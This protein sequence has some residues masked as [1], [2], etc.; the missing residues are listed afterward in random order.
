MYE[1]RLRRLLAVF[2]VLLGVIGARAFSLQV[3]GAEESAGRTW[4]SLADRSREF[5][6]H[7]RRGEILW[8]DGSKMVSNVPTYGLEILWGTVDLRI[9][10]TVEDLRAAYPAGLSAERRSA[11]ESKLRRVR[12]KLLMPAGATQPQQRWACRYCGTQRASRGAPTRRCRDCTSLDY[13]EVP[14]LY[15]EDLAILLETSVHRVHVALIAAMGR[16]EMNTHWRSHAMLARIPDSAVE[17]LSLF[18]ER[19]AGLVPLARNGREVDAAGRMIAGG[20]RLPDREDLA[21]LTDERRAARGLHV[22]RTESVS[23]ALV[24]SS[25][26][27]KE[28]DELLRGIPGLSERSRTRASDF[29]ARTDV[30]RPVQDGTDLR[31]TL[32]RNVQLLA[33]EEVERGAPEGGHGAAVVLDV[34]SGAVIALASTSRDA[35]DHARSHVMPGSVYKIVTAV[36][37]LEAGHSPDEILTCEGRARIATGGRYVCMHSDGDIAL[38][39]AFVRSCN[40][41][42]SQ[43]AAAVGADG[44][45]AAARR[46]GLA[47]RPLLGTFGSGRSTRAGLEYSRPGKGDP[48]LWR[49]WNLPQIGI[50]QGAASASPLQIAVAYARIAAGGRLLQPFVLER[51]RPDPA[52][53]P[54]DP[55]LARWA[56]FLRDAARSVVADEEHGTARREAALAALR[57]AGKT[58]TADTQVRGVKRNNTSFVGYAPYD[59]PRYCAIVVFENMPQKRYG[60]EAAGDPVAR[61]L[62]EALRE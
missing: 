23:P 21:R 2:Y 8:A 48:E 34:R 36:A 11:L 49:R 56:P 39:D 62:A 25:L 37:L 29:E 18:P 9:V 19:F 20:T 44:L 43:Q 4:A 26:I 13:E 10:P 22:F 5:I 59:D 16:W 54:V 7:P 31:T 55:V 61:L 17:S 15:P 42:F 35:M 32:L 47:A 33:L 27:E 30:I 28:Y 60:A 38:R 1:Q 52:T 53:I 41:Y 40:G 57:A 51:D 12:P 6:V 14:P 3:L 46:L 50:G 24:G 58:G 45:V